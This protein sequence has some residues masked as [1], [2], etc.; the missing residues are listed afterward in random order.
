MS[1]S[2]QWRF[3]GWRG[4]TV[5]EN[6]VWLR[7]IHSLFRGK[8]SVRRNPIWFGPDNQR[9]ENLQYGLGVCLSSWWMHVAPSR[10]RRVTSIHP[11]RENISSTRRGPLLMRLEIV[12]RRREGQLLA[13]RP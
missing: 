4:C 13:E 11:G 2:Q 8:K 5:V 12:P 1:P 9:E 7:A 3:K 10:Q 6:M